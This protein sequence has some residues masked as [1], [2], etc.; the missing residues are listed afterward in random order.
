MKILIV[1]DDTIQRRILEAA[2][3]KAG[4]D[5]EALKDGQEAWDR[6]Q[7]DPPRL[8]ITDWMMPRMDGTDLIRNIRAAGW[9]TYT[10]TLLVTALDDPDDVIEGL[11]AGAD[12]YLT[13]PVDH[14]ELVAR[15][16]IGRRLVELEDNLR[17]TQDRL[18]ELASHD[19]MTGLLNR[20]AI[21]EHAH[22]ELS[23]GARTGTSV[24]LA[25][26]DIDHFKAVNDQHGHLTGDVAL[27]SVAETLKQNKRPYDWV[28]RWGGEEFLVVLPDT[29]LAAAGVVAERLRA[30]VSKRTIA[31]PDGEELSVTAS[32]GVVSVRPTTETDLI[33]LLREADTAL[34]A[35]KRL[36]RNR[37]ELAPPHPTDS[38]IDGAP[39]Q[40]SA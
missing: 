14:R 12:D 13:K 20:Q 6:M 5:V 39:A 8:V 25:L 17:A 7:S 10:Y 38:A 3:R 36:G 11:A 4:Y 23:R 9:S 37:V 19:A 24:S 32:L 18:L 26:L 33:D 29:S 30:A 27:C 22:A 15:V 40:L 35:A 34:Y 2:L 21:H 16:A 1:D 31:L 28:G